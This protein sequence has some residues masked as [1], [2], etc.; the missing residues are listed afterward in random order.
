MS[1]NMKQG[2]RIRVLTFPCIIALLF[3][4]GD[5]N[6]VLAS[7]TG[8]P[9]T[10]LHYRHYRDCCN[11]RE[12]SPNAVANSDYRTKHSPGIYRGAFFI[13]SGMCAVA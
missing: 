4:I 3:T 6:D 10:Q 8:S 9:I 12:S 7:R 5:I 1:E 11:D 13:S 2:S